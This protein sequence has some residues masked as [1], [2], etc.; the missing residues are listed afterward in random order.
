[1]KLEQTNYAGN[2]IILTSEKNRD[3]GNPILNLDVVSSVYGASTIKTGIVVTEQGTPDMTVKISEGIVRDN[4]VGHLLTAEAQTA[5]TILAA[6]ITQDRRDIIEVRRLME[7]TTPEARQFKDP[8]TETISTA[9]IDTIKEY[10]T[11]FKV[12]TGVPGAIA[13]AVEPGWIKVAEILIPASSSSVVNANIFN[14]DAEA[15]GLNNTGWSNDITAMYRHG[16]DSDIKTAISNLWT[17]GIDGW[18]EDRVYPLLGYTE[19]QGMIWQSDEVDNINQQPSTNQD[20]WKVVSAPKTQQIVFDTEAIAIGWDEPT[21]IVDTV[22][23]NVTIQVIPPPKYKGQK[24][25]VYSE[26]TGVVF[27]PTGNGLY[28][29]G[30]YISPGKKATF[31]GIGGGLWVADN[32][33]TADYIN[34][35]I[36]I[37]LNAS[38]NYR[39]LIKANLTASIPGGAL[40]YNFADILLPMTVTSV[41]ENIPASSDTTAGWGSAGQTTTTTTRVIFW[42]YTTATANIGVRIEGKYA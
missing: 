9:T 36:G 40:F 26:G 34:G 2:E 13:T 35:G 28:S 17:K 25:T 7:T 21:A 5:L 23:G 19:D 6:D 41:S 22:L 12:L 8:N 3:A 33:V 24:L 42:S 14:S 29:G 38:G 30:V 16:S 18:K 1:M 20:K 10:K 32:V 37:K 31:E 4:V 15:E 39:F 27:I 11:E